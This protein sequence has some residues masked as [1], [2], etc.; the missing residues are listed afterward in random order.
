[1]LR[2]SPRSIALAGVAA[3]GAG[4][5]CAPAAHA[6]ACRGQL[7]LEAEYY[8]TPI[9]GYASCVATGDWNEDGQADLAVAHDGST[10]TILRGL[11]GFRVGPRE[12]IPVSATPSWVVSRDMDGDGHQD[13]VVTGDGGTRIMAGDGVGGFH[14]TE[15]FAESGGRAAVGDLDG[16]GKPDIVLASYTAPRLTVIFRGTGER[17]ALPGWTYGTYFA[18]LADF[19]R[20]GDLDLASAGTL[21]WLNDGHGHFS[22]PTSYPPYCLPYY[23]AAGD[24]NGDGNLDL[25]GVTT[26]D[27]GGGGCDMVLLG[28]GDGTFHAGAI[29]GVAQPV[30]EPRPSRRSGVLGPETGPSTGADPQWVPQ[31][32]RHIPPG[33]EFVVLVDLDG[34]G[35][36]DPIRIG[37]DRGYELNGRRTLSGAFMA[38]AA[39]MDGDGK[40]DMVVAGGGAIGI[41]PGNG[42]GTFRSNL[43][44]WTQYPPQDVVLADLD[45]DGRRD[46]AMTSIEDELI[47]ALTAPDGGFRRIIRNP[48]SSYSSSIAIADFDGDGR[49]DLLEAYEGLYLGNGDGT[50]R[51]PYIPTDAF[52]VPGDFNEDGHVDLADPEVH[53]VQLHLGNG[54]GTFRTGPTIAVEALELRAADMDHDGHLD[55]VA[56]GHGG[57]ISVVY[58][59]GD[60][61]ADEIVEIPTTYFASVS[62]GDLD[63]DALV[64]MIAPSS[65]GMAVYLSRGRTLVRS[66]FAG[67]PSYPAIGDMNGDSI[68]DLVAGGIWLGH[69]DGTFDP[70]DILFG[71]PGRVLLDDRDGDGLG[72]VVVAGS[73]D[74]DGHENTL[75]LIMNGTVRNRAPVT[76]SAHAGVRPTWPPNGEFVEVAITG[77]T[78]PDGDAVSIK[79]LGVTQDEPVAGGQAPP[80]VTR[81][82]LCADAII[83][84]G[85][86]A[87]V[88]LARDGAGNG[89]VYEIAYSASDGCGGTSLGRVRVD[90]PHDPGKP[91][92]DD[93]QRFNSLACGVSK[94]A[95]QQADAAAQ[96]LAVERLAPGRWTIRYTLAAAADVHLDVFDLLGRRV[97]SLDSGRREPG[98]HE[99]AWTPSRHDGVYFIRLI[100]GSRSTVR[101]C[102]VLE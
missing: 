20:D 100:D 3:L 27:G 62:L 4:L 44:T 35:K 39:D 65:T 19:D 15:A 36:A 91:C 32:P 92:V 16:D 94:F 76:T 31:S 6:A 2:N 41:H 96:P 72:D 66:P 24:V 84:A 17:L 7:Q 78:D 55:L 21:V 22:G 43:S 13:L 53:A 95:A 34:D 87:R 12:E 48:V 71:P 9:P 51:T 1:M 33:P 50:F 47:V 89:R 90:I 101:R 30:Q 38:C 37:G 74:E 86:Y 67:A 81:G 18:V 58:G 64:D 80:G 69:G 61:T 10:L 93:G 42:N 14:E 8:V 25:F 5:V 45:G 49:A 57:T 70:P 99:T 79:C 40:L 82:Q 97:A 52:G 73:Y 77:V 54:D 28:N 23:E 59:R 56:T 11:G 85:G 68:A 63:G 88:R 83:D 46:V 60:G 75:T 26:R 29:A 98:T 102:V